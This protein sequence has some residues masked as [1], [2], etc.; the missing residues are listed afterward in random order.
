MTNGM[1]K[2]RKLLKKNGGVI[3]NMKFTSED[4]MKAM[5]LSVGDRI[6]LRGRYYTIEI[7]ELSGLPVYANDKRYYNMIGLINQDIDILPRPKRVGDTLCKQYCSG[8]PLIALQCFG[9]E[10]ENKP[11]Y[12]VLDYALP[13]YH[14]QEIHDLL[15]ARLDKEVEE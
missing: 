11:L 9:D 6:K 2:C 3:I 8:C 4:L 1:M 7:N 10:T 5:G 12:E 14:D 15:K 13:K